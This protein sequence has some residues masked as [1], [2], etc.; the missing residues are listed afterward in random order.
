MA[1]RDAADLIVGPRRMRPEG[2][3]N[4]CNPCS[5]SR[6]LAEPTNRRA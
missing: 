6:S 4:R 5:G 3:A 2:D 1:A